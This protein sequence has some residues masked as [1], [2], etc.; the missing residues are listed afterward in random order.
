MVEAISPLWNGPLSPTKPT[1]IDMPLRPAQM[2][3]LKP[4]LDQI[5]PSRSSPPHSPAYLALARHPSSLEEQLTKRLVK[6]MRSTEW[7]HNLQT[8]H[9]RGSRPLPPPVTPEKGVASKESPPACHQTIRNFGFTQGLASSAWS[10]CC[11]TG[12]CSHPV[13]SASCSLFWRVVAGKV[14]WRRQMLCQSW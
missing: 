8:C 6:P 10:C 1:D 3:T 9:P 2:M 11:R 4:S 12:L 5:S 7:L 14:L 13:S